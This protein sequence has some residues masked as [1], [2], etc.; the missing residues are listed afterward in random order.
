M[1]SSKP[2]FE[3]LEKPKDEWRR[4]LPL[5]QYSVLFEEATERPFSH[6]LNHEKGEGTFVCASCGLPYSFPMR[7]SKAAL[8]GL[9]SPKPFQGT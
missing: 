8:A 2:D 3:P 9:A 4:I 6:P 7:S 1:P 5:D